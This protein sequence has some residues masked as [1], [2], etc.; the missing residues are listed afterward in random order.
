LIAGLRRNKQSLP[1]QASEAAYKK[2]KK[3]DG[4]IF[5]W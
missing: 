1:T 2:T 3:G 4:G 5:E